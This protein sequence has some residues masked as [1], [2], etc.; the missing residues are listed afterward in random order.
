VCV[1]RFRSGVGKAEIR[2]AVYLFLSVNTVFLREVLWKKIVEKDFF[3]T[4]VTRVYVHA[5]ACVRV[6]ACVC[7]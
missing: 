4:R 6:C 3:P 1:C 2:C 7:V 5:C